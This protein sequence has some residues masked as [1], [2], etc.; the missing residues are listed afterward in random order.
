MSEANPGARGPVSQLTVIPHISSLMR[1]L[2]GVRIEAR[3]VTTNRYAIIVFWSEDDRAWVGD[4]PD[5][6]S[7]AAF[8]STPEEAF[9]EVRIAMDAWLAAARDA[10]LE[11]PKPR[12]RPHYEAAE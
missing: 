3:R 5:L 9:A 11:I 4:V 2:A 8:G 10:G 1:A 6:K 7:C 12:F